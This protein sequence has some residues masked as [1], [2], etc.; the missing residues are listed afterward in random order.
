[1]LCC[2]R[3]DPRRAKYRLTYFDVRGL[4]EPIRMIFQYEGVPFNDVRLSMEE[5][6]EFKESRLRELMNKLSWVT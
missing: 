2:R 3:T 5:W 1:M 4:G 6:A